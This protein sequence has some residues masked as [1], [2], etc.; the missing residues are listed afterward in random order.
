M[1][2]TEATDPEGRTWT[3]RRRWTPRWARVDVRRRFRIG[4]PQ[5]TVGERD[6]RPRRFDWLD[7]IDIPFGDELPVVGAIL[8]VAAMAAVAWFVVIPLLLVVFDLVVVVVLLVCLAALRILF[9]R[10]WRIEATGPG[11]RR[12]ERDVVGWRRS[13]EAID[14]LRDEIAAGIAQRDRSTG[15]SAVT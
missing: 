6:A 5:Y 12:I 3:I 13:T 7:V 2:G 9:R 11:E 8:A 1:R 4:R 10:P 15:S 14:R